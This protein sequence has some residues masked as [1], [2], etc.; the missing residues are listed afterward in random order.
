MRLTSGQPLFSRGW[1]HIVASVD[2]LFGDA[3]SSATHCVGC[4][5]GEERLQFT[6]C[7][8]GACEELR[9]QSAALLQVRGMLQRNDLFE[10][11]K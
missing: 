9:G 3:L 1:R 10:G 4:R 2:D 7:A 8:L 5:G 6:N 11:S